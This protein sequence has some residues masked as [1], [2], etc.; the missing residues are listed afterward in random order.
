MS[1]LPSKANVPMAIVRR[2]DKM[3]ATERNGLRILEEFGV[4]IDTHRDQPHVG[5]FAEDIHR[6]QCVP[7]PIDYMI[8]DDIL[9]NRETGILLQRHDKHL[10][11]T[12]DEW[13]NFLVTSLME[14]G[15]DPRSG[16]G[17]LP[18]SHF[19]DARHKIYLLKSFRQMVMNRYLR[20]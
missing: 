4:F 8:G 14:S 9:I 7:T 13:S 15:V 5:G 20:P 11:I 19:R 3:P 10:F 16:D 1:H 6:G 2:L 18:T 12:N 17:S